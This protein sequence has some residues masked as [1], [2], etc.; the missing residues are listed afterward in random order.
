M[1]RVNI[2]EIF[3][4]YL[5]ILI[6]FVLFVKPTIQYKYK[7]CHNDHVNIDSLLTKYC[8]SNCFIDL[9]SLVTGKFD[10]KLQKSWSLVAF[11]K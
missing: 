8:I 1:L 10:L 9:W 6:M 5:L 4:F 3:S 11:Y 2:L 7:G